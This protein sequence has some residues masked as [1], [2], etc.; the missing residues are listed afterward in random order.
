MPR[1]LYSRSDLDNLKTFTREQILDAFGS[2]ED[3]DLDL[4]DAAFTRRI[5]TL[6]NP[7]SITGLS[8]AV[9]NSDT[10][11]IGHAILTACTG[12]SP[13]PSTADDET[14]RLAEDVLNHRFKFYT[15]THQLPENIDW[16]FN[17]GTAHWSHD[18]NRFS[19]LSILTRAY[20]STKDERFSRKAI[21]LIL[22]W[23]TKCDIGQCF[24]STPYVFGS[25]LNNAIHCS[26]WAH[27]LQHLLPTN[28]V[29]PFELLRIL[30]S[31]HDQMAYLEIV[32][33]GHGGNWPTIG[34]QGI[35]Q[36]HAAFPI[37]RDTERLITYC[38][39]TLAEQIDEQ[40][41]PDGAQDELTPHY[42]AVVVNNLLTAS[43]SLH[44]LNRTLE[45]RTLDTLRKMVHYQQQTVV[46]NR[47]AQIAFNDSDPESVPNTAPRLEALGLSDYLTPPETLGP[48][49][50]PYAGVAFL[51][52]QADKGDLYL[53]F[54]GGP[55]GRSHQ[56][57]DKLGFWLHAYG[58]NFI[59]DPGRHL[60][61]RSEASYLN[62]LK[63]THAHATI[64]IDGQ[65]QNSRNHPDT[66]IATE[67]VP[68][69]F[70]VSENEIR[71]SA[72]YDLGYGPE[73]EIEVTHRRE[74]VFAN[75]EFWIVFDRVEGNGEHLIESRFPFYPGDLALNN[76]QITT[77]YNDANLLLCSCAP[78][79]DTQIQK[80]QDNPKSGWYSAS[81]SRIEPA[82]C[83]VLSAKTNLP[84]TSATLLYPYRGTTA[85]TLTFTFDN[86]TA[87]V[88]HPDH[89]EHAVSCSFA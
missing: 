70:T 10:I 57:E 75:E 49:L 84:F 50:F 71:A 76:N 63:S 1:P 27:C 24:K 40:I 68:L 66:W 4:D 23:I 52:Q 47:S 83:L 34:C 5:A 35:L 51:R 36:I 65:N 56:H 43:E 33:N 60:Y 13:E 37:F 14:L 77:Q 39:D 11:A 85:P 16:D 48:E 62:F 38:I 81:Y 7:D 21:D 25:Y 53:A 22:D 29:K 61:D 88:N 9:Q 6:L 64:T 15:E 46:P 18:L 59:V 80:G 69:A 72:T 26:A 44:I 3:R 20:L 19:Y 82:P 87:I 73:N 8:E 31:L 54:D 41:L 30:K 58:R 12:N 67:P 89:K 78:W 2:F 79:E 45:P 55:Y 32:T 42:H 28:Q 17:P 86:L 74:I